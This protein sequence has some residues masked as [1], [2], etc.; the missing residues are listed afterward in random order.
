MIEGKDEDPQ[1]SLEERER[2]KKE[3]QIFLDS[4]GQK[5]FSSFDMREDLIDT[6]IIGY[7]DFDVEDFLV[8]AYFSLLINDEA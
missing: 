7:E 8:H 5:C 2:V 6:T 4:Y 3:V 1:V